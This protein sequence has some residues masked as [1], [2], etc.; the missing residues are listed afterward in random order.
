MPLTQGT[1]KIIDF[2]VK[3]LG[4]CDTTSFYVNAIPNVEV[5][6]QTPDSS[7]IYKIFPVFNYRAWIE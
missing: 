6:I 7:K 1:S 3:I 5:Y 2:T 4:I